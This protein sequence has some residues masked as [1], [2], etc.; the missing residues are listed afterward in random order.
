MA[1][2]SPP[3]AAKSR[4]GASGTSP[5]PEKEE[6]SK[7]LRCP[8]CAA[9]MQPVVFKDVEFDRCVDC[10]GLWFD[11][12]EHED[13]KKLAGSEAIDIGDASRGRQTNKLDK[14]ECPAC[15]ASM[16]RLVDPGQ[17]HIWLESCAKC[18][19]VF[20]DAG[21]FRDWKEHHA[22]DWIKSM[23]TRERR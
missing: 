3:K 8:K 4:A 18:F 2:K 21:E 16:V 5:S 14:I 6:R 7:L 9:T 13:L 22:F 11:L 15:H 23:L 12:L 17:P 1:K 20:F 19:G 10:R